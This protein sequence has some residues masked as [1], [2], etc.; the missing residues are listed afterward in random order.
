M[1]KTVL[2]Q[3]RQVG[4]LAARRSRAVPSTGSGTRYNPVGEF[5]VNANASIQ[6][7]LIEA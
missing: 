5:A 2:S 6:S 1:L 3:L 7:R 4:L